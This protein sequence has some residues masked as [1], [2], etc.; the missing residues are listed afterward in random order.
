MI[1]LI[2]AVTV[3]VTTVV[4]MVARHE[5]R[6]RWVS[7]WLIVCREFS[8]VWWRV[9]DSRRVLGNNQSKEKRK[10]GLIR[11]AFLCTR[12]VDPEDLQEPSM[13]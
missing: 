11:V 12:D 4:M 10:F 8:D 13:N 2:M 6:S 1:V 3:S 9:G 7:H 5:K